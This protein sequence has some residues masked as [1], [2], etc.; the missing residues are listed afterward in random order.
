MYMRISM[1]NK[2]FPFRIIANSF[3]SF[4]KKVPFNSPDNRKT[5]AQIKSQD[6]LILRITTYEKYLFRRHVAHAHQRTI[7]MF[8][9]AD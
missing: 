8:D 9:C 5:E 2:N 6:D 1:H 3:L 7:T 4:L